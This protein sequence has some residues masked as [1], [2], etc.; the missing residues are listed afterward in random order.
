[1]NPE[2]LS[3]RQPNFQSTPEYEPGRLTVKLEGEGNLDAIDA[4]KTVLTGAHTEAQR[5]AVKEV[6]V[7]LTELEFLN[8][9]GIKHFVSWLREA[10]LLPPETSY[11]IRLISSPLV[12]WQRR[13]LNALQ[14][15]APKLLTI[16]T[17]PSAS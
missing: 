1:M 12:P 15:F 3:F 2:K 9:S 6:V 11:S 16:D 5:L 10:S 4:I 7:D 14:C 17:R 8:S 13:S